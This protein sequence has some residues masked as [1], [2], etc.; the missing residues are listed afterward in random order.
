MNEKI[1]AVR[2]MFGF[3]NSEAKRYIANAPSDCIDTIVL[4]WKKQTGLSFNND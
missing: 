2:W 1:T 3:T 4:C